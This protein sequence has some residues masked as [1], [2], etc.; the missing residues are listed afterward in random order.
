MFVRS[1]VDGIDRRSRVLN[2]LDEIERTSLDF[3]ATVRSLYRQ[4][5]TDEINNGTRPP[6]VPGPSIMSD[7][8]V[9]EAP[10]PVSDSE[11]ASL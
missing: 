6:E 4:R 3:Y 7:D 8:G 2:V 5:R 9:N 10:S 11:K 1:F